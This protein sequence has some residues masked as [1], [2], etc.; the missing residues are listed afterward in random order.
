MNRILKTLLIGLAAA[1]VVYLV[2]KRQREAR[3]VPRQ[4]PPADLSE[5]EVSLLLRELD[6][7]L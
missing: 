5:A 3:A 1:G 4:A 7:H 2:G 6:S